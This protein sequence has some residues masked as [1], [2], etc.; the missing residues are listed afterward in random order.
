M[1]M[2]HE[3]HQ[4]MLIACGT[5]CDRCGATQL[6]EPETESQGDLPP[7]ATVTVAR[8]AQGGMLRG[9]FCSSCDEM[10]RASPG[11]WLPHL[12]V[13]SRFMPDRGYWTYRF[14]VRDAVT[15][16]LSWIDSLSYDEDLI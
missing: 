7:F 3:H 12:R 9:H 13:V 15:G 1:K 14:Q 16:Q 11:V 5:M 4:V 2:V 6:H 10:L 8:G